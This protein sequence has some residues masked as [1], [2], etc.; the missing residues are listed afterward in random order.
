VITITRQYEEK[1][2]DVLDDIYTKAQQLKMPLRAI[3]K[4]SGLCYQTVRRHSR[5]ESRL[6]Q[7]RTIFNLASAVG[8]D[9]RIVR[10]TN[11]KVQK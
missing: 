1:L 2:Q 3:A 9:V 11:A 6:P 5:F 10:Q 8:L 7:M 4:K